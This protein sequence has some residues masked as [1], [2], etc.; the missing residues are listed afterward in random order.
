MFESSPKKGDV[1]FFDN[2]YDENKD[3]EVN[4][5]LTGIGFIV[6]IDKEDTI[7]Y[8]TKTSKGIEMKQMNLKMKDQ[9]SIKDKNLTKTVNSQT[10]WQ[11]AKEKKAGV[12]V[13]TLSAQQFNSFGSFFK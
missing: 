13:P 11:T 2:S 4:D 1:I 6:E 10:R 3:G 12:E 9:A 5:K 7:H 8:L